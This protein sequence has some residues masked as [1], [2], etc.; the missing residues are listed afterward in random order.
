MPAPVIVAFDFGGTKTGVAVCEPDGTQLDTAAVPV[1]ASAGAQHNLHGAI[2]RV[3]AMLAASARGRPIAGVGAATFGIP[4]STGIALATAV[5][6]WAELALESEL[7]VAFPDATVSVANDVKA[8]AAAEVTFGRLAGCDPGIY[9]NLGTGLAAAIVV[10]GTVLNGRHGASGEIGYN[11]RSREAI[12]RPD[13]RTILEDFVSGGALSRRG[14]VLFGRPV[15]AAEVLSVAATD[16]RIRYLVDDFVGELA[17]HL[18]NL[19]NAVDPQR[20]VF[21]GGMTAAWQLLHPALRAALD[22]AVPYP[23]ELVQAAFPDTAALI[24]AI[25]L[26]TRAAT[27]PPA[28]QASHN[29]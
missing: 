10:D 2:E 5:D 13:D 18:V 20:I 25:A 17:F 3:R 11:L 29:H 15:S 26:G 21:G 27:S 19:A 12:D 4:M 28:A 7:R 1:S 16:H 23:P 24:G 22:A 14:E 6:G 9:L 8:A